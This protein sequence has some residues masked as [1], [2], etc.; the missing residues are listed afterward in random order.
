MTVM[1][2]TVLEI[3]NVTFSNAFC[4]AVAQ[5][6]RTERSYVTFQSYSPW[7]RRLMSASSALGLVFMIS[8]PIHSYSNSSAAF[9]GSVVKP[10]LISRYIAAVNAGDTL[11]YVQRELLKSGISKSFSILPIGNANRSPTPSPAATPYY[12]FVLV[13]AAIVGG[14]LLLI[15]LSGWLFITMRRRT[16]RSIEIKYRS[17]SE[18]A[19]DEEMSMGNI[20]SPPS[21]DS[22][23]DYLSITN[24]YLRGGEEQKDMALTIIDQPEVELDFNTIEAADNTNVDTENPKTGDIAIQGGKSMTEIKLKSALKKVSKYDS[25]GFDSPVSMPMASLGQASE[26]DRARWASTEFPFPPTISSKSTATRFAHP[27]LPTGLAAARARS[28]RI[29]ELPQEDDIPVVE[30]FKSADVPAMSPRRRFRLS[31]LK[32]EL[33]N[34]ENW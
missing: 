25:T 26:E 4:T 10:L 16:Q 2:L 20:Y 13:V 9:N 11:R 21:S 29:V 30:V 24:E 3:S 5:S 1:N 34:E 6:M 14:A 7:Q 19:I 31:R 18:P 17:M 28:I 27:A 23:N 12:I 15:A 33:K 8:L 32:F 22:E